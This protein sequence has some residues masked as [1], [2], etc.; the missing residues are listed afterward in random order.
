MPNLYPFPAVPNGQYGIT[1][2]LKLG[3]YFTFYVK[4]LLY[5][6]SIHYVHCLSSN[7][8]SIIMPRPNMVWRHLIPDTYYQDF[9]CI[10]TAR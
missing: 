10:I 6:A 7:K 8:Y 5:F 3:L 1:L 9:G 2:R 4:I